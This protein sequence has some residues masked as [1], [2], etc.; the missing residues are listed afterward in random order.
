[1]LAQELIARKRDGAELTDEE[2]RE[3]LL[4]I[5]WDHAADAYV[6]FGFL[7]GAAHYVFARRVKG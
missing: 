6:R 7:P 1:M 2:F 4:Q 3:F 5:R